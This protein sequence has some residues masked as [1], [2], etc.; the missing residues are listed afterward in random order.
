MIL[1]TYLLI[2]PEFSLDRNRDLV[3]VYFGSIQELLQETTL[4][5]LLLDEGFCHGGWVGN[6]S[7][8]DQRKAKWNICDIIEH[9][10]F[11]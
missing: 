9:C 6:T 10:A 3:W 8:S 4:P 2:L 11:G 7:L 1:L 5:V